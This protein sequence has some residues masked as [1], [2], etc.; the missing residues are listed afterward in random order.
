MLTKSLKKASKCKINLGLI[1]HYRKMHQCVHLPVSTF[2]L[3]N[4]ISLDESPLH[5]VAY[6]VT[7]NKHSD[8]TD[9]WS[10][11]NFRCTYSTRNSHTRQDSKRSW[12]RSKCQSVELSCWQ[13][14]FTL[15]KNIFSW[16]QKWWT[17]TN[18]LVRIK[19]TNWYTCEVLTE[20]HHCSHISPHLL[21]HWW[22]HAPSSSAI[23]PC[24]HLAH[25]AHRDIISQQVSLLDK[26]SASWWQKRWTAP[27]HQV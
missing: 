15:H 21:P 23:W 9:D 12:R 24:I 2:L 27:I 10:L 18:F 1:T 14:S 7:C 5:N 11:L 17:Q 3:K 13:L 4:D 19:N 22:H 26:N 25:V 16:W 20:G 6:C 8:E